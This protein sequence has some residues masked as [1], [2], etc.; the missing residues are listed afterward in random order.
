[1][2][3]CASAVQDWFYALSA[4]GGGSIDGSSLFSVQ[5]K[6]SIK[7]LQQILTLIDDA[8][9]LDSDASRRAPWFNEQLCQRKAAVLFLRKSFMHIHRNFERFV[10]D[11][12]MRSSS[13]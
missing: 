12:W 5:E 8:V 2:S 7:A 4:S 9:S 1:M 3:G 6:N 10:S 13:V 11:A